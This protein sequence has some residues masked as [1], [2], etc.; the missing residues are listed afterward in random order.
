MGP[1]ECTKRSKYPGRCP[2]NCL[3]RAFAAKHSS[4]GFVHSK[5]TLM[6][7]VR[8][9]SAFCEMTLKLYWNRLLVL[10]ITKELLP[11]LR[12]VGSHSSDSP[13]TLRSVDA[14]L[15]L[16]LLRV[17]W[18]APHQ[19]PERRSCRHGALAARA[20]C[21]PGHAMSAL[22]GASASMMHR[23]AYRPR[24]LSGIC[25]PASPC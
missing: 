18:F 19:A 15:L 3:L 22:P 12:L 16:G 21:C 25:R 17:L 5:L 8:F 10:A 23:C 9:A 4:L 2:L 14:C 11:S 24:R 7:S 6:Q 13:R 20:P 1:I